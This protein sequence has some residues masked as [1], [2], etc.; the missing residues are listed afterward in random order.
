[1]FGGVGSAGHEGFV[2]AVEWMH[3]APE[4]PGG[5]FPMLLLAVGRLVQVGQLADE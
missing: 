2:N 4:A 3:A 1:V 5:E